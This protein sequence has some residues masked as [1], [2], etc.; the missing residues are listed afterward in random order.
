MFYQKIDWLTLVVM[1]DSPISILKLLHADSIL[2]DLVVNQFDRDQGYDTRRVFSF[3]GVSF[4]FDL[5]KALVNDKDN[6]GYGVFSAIYQ[7]FRV[8][9]SGSGLDYLRD[10]GFDVNSFLSYIRDNFEPDHIRPTRIDY[11]FDIVNYEQEVLYSFINEI[12]ACELS[13][14]LDPSSRLR[15]INSRPS[16]NNYSYRFG[17]GQ[18]TFYFGTPRSESLLRIYDKRLQFLNGSK[19]FPAFEEVK[20]HEPVNSWIRFELQTRSRFCCNFLRSNNS[21]LDVWKYICSNYRAI[22]PSTGH[23]FSSLDQFFD[24]FYVDGQLDEMKNIWHDFYN[25][26]TTFQ[27]TCD[28]LWA[29]ARK[30]VMYFAVKNGSRFLIDL[31]NYEFYKLILSTDPKDISR[32][33]AFS[34]FLAQD[35]AVNGDIYARSDI[36]KRLS[37]CSSSDDYLDILSGDLPC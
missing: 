25:P 4:D 19:T 17:N 3:N 22:D 33:R 27:E 18:A 23:C 6:D 12:K 26:I 28:I 32:R 11:A 15:F 9:I 30:I 16:G 20:R 5:E 13:G 37:D 34:V 31:I 7:K 36:I 1:N 8:D 21:M 29:R 10:I 24:S 14:L 35:R 2:D